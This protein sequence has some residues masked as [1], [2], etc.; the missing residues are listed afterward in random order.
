IF[1]FM[2]RDFSKFALQVLGKPSSTPEQVEYCRKMIM[3]PEFDADRY[4]RVWTQ[5]VLPL[6]DAY[7]M[8]P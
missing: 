7:E 1:D 8:N 2:V 5:Q 3:K 6:K 4:N